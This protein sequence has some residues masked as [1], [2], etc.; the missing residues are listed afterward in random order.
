M[1]GIRPIITISNRM[2]WLRRQNNI[3]DIETSISGAP[4]IDAT[5]MECVME[6]IFRDASNE[7]LLRLNKYL[8]ESLKQRSTPVKLAL[9]AYNATF[10]D[11]C[12]SDE[13]RTEVYKPFVVKYLSHYHPT[14]VSDE[15]VDLITNYLSRYDFEESPVNDIARI[16]GCS[17]AQA[18]QS[19]DI[20]NDL[21][22]YEGFNS[23]DEFFSMKVDDP[24][25]IAAVERLIEQGKPPKDIIL[26]IIDVP[27][28][29]KIKQCFDQCYGDYVVLVD[30]D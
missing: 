28:G 22:E 4:M 2:T 14:W 16:T 17:I 3:S 21:C 27:L 11:R 13:L 9:S 10:A 7:T 18:E 23:C 29:K 8:K 19:L 24:Y 5:L 26:I 1:N 25:F 12:G 20:L 30:D 15:V 6:R